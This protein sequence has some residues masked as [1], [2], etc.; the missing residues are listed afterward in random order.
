MVETLDLL[1]AGQTLPAI[2]V[3][4]GRLKAIS[5]VVLTEGGWAQAQHHEVTRSNRTGILTGRDQRNAQRD[6]RE[7]QRLAAGGRGGPLP[8]RGQRSQE[9]R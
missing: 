4:L 6:H 8:P 9:Q 1:R 2:M 5:S 7:V 3:L